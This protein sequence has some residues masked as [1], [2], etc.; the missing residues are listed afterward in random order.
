MTAYTDV[1]RRVCVT[2]AQPPVT[3]SS[4][5][6]DYVSYAV[7]S[8]QGPLQQLP[9]LT[10]IQHALSLAISWRARFSKRLELQRFE[11]RVEREMEGCKADARQSVLLQCL[12]TD[13]AQRPIAIDWRAFD[14]PFE[15]AGSMPPLLRHEVEMWLKTVWALLRPYEERLTLDEFK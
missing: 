6:S 12:D 11:S 8:P 14:T 4:L 7:P 9:L 15:E 3:D 2:L 10:N 1:C 13:N 5:A